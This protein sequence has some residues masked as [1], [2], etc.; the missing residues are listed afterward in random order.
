MS[1]YI[2]FSTFHFIQFK[3]VTHTE[4]YLAHDLTQCVV[5]PILKFNVVCPPHNFTTLRRLSKKVKVPEFALLLS[6]VS[7]MKLRV[8]CLCG[9]ISYLFTYLL[10]LIWDIVDRI[11]TWAGTGRPGNRDSIPAQGNTFFSS[12]KHPGWL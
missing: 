3:T 6:D 12:I 5:E 2:T 4:I 9:L 11:R 10:H 7:V 8:F 1:C